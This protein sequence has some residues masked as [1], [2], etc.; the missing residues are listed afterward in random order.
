MPPRSSSTVSGGALND[1]GAA[2]TVFNVVGGSAT[3]V[4][5]GTI[6]QTGNA[7][8]MVDIS[9]TH[10][11]NITFGGNLTASQGVGMVFNDAD[12]TYTI[13]GATNAFTAGAGININ[14]TSIGNFSFNSGTSVTNGLVGANTACLVVNGSNPAELVLGTGAADTMRGNQNDDCILGGAGNDN[15]RGDNGTDEFTARQAWLYVS[16]LGAGY[17]ISRGLAKSG[18][19]EPYTDEHGAADLRDRN[20]AR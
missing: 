8:P 5:N 18:S 10:T 20:G 15:L 3:I 2:N 7:A 6:S 16:I 14:N 4:W 19:R 1:S 11:G 17:F 12:G 13:S 9:G